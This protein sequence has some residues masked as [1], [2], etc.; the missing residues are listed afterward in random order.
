MK[1]TIAQKLENEVNNARGLVRRL[2]ELGSKMTAPCD[3]GSI[4]FATLDELR[5]LADRLEEIGGNK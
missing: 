4:Y 2:S 1:F 5:E 3:T